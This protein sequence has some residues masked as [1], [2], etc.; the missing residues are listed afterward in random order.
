MSPPVARADIEAKLRQITDEVGRT[1][2]AAKPNLMAIA[3]AVAAGLVALAFLAG[4]RRG[5]RKATV[6]EIRRV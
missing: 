3:A 4:K 1:A 5:K 6:V 2:E